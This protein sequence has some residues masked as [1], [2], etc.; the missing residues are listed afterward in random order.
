MIKERRSGAVGE[1]GFLASAQAEGGVQFADTP[2][3]RAWLMERRRSQRTAVSLVPFA[4]L[5]GWR[6]EQGSGDL[7]HESGRF[8][9]VQGV[10]ATS[11]FPAFTAVQ[12]P[13]INQ[14]EVGVLGILAK[15]FDGIVHFLLQAK[16]EPGNTGLVQLSPTVQATRSNYTRVHGGA[17]PRYLEFFL[18]RAHGRVVVDQLQSEQGLFFLR[19]RNRNIIVETGADVPIDE[20]LAKLPAG[21][22]KIEG[23]SMENG[24][25]SGKTEGTAWLTHNIPAGAELL[26][27]AAGAT[28]ARPRGCRGRPWRARSREPPSRPR[29]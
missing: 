20:M 11:D 6:F 24:E 15:R 23:P 26:T 25:S 14:P 3:A 29:H 16:M 9:R 12:Q 21:N 10:C 7:V 2:A 28:T 18:E 22:Y 4:D 17:R 27:P 5:Q 8:F 19:K 13:I 1:P